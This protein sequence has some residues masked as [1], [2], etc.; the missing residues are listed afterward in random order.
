MASEKKGIPSFLD[1]KKELEQLKSKTN[2][3]SAQKKVEKLIKK[4]ENDFKKLIHENIPDV[5]RKFQDEK[6][7][8][9]V[10]VDKIIKEEIKRAKAIVDSQKKEFSRLQKKIETI[11]K[12]KKKTSVKSKTKSK[13]TKKSP[14]KSSSKSTS[15]AVPKNKVLIKKA[16]RS[17]H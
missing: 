2:F 4:A 7:Q 17:S 13:S 3:K 5:M 10:L 12:N 14:S 8:I 16:K 11:L 15:K 9:E 6:K 1:I